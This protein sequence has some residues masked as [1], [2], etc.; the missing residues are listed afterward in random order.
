[1]LLVDRGA[2][3]RKA[4]LWTSVQLQSQQAHTW[5][6]CRAGPRVESRREH[7]QAATLEALGEFG[8]EEQRGLDAGHEAQEGQQEKAQEQAVAQRVVQAPARG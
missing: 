5:F 6:C 1:V 3:I 4:R 2:G 8:V 7:Q